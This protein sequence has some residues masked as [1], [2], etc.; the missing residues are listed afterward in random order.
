M[1][2]FIIFELKNDKKDRY[3]ALNYISICML[4]EP[5]S[6]LLAFLLISIVLQT[7]LLLRE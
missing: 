5:M 7:F 4:I 6:D 2:F 1:H 3:N